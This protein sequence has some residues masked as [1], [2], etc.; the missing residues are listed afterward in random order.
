MSEDIFRHKKII[1]AKL[2]PYGF[3]KYGN[4]YIYD[5]HI[6]NDE[7]HLQVTVEKNSLPATKLT[8]SATGE[9]YFL[10]KTDSVGAYI[11]EVRAAVFEVLQDIAARCCEVAIFKAEQSE[12]LIGYI[13]E[14]YG[15]EL[16]FLWKKFPDNAIWRRKDSGKWYG[17]LL[18]ISRRKL[19][20]DS[21]EIV[22]IIDLRSKPEQLEKLIDGER[23]FLGWHMNKRHWYTIIL[24][25][26]VPFVELCR[27]IDESYLLAK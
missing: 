6:L 12:K 24:D 19:G 15:D 10:H 22:E 25:G 16:E 21:D 27:L 3:K 17:V 9:E 11:G 13:R 14:K 7:F 4:A 20:F 23:Y 18:T 8:E 5:T 1:L 26:S 2:E